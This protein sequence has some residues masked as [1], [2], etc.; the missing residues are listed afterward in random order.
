M[1]F[2][3]TISIASANPLNTT[4]DNS[5]NAQFINESYDVS[6]DILKYTHG[7]TTANSEVTI[8]PIMDPY[9]LAKAGVSGALPDRKGPS[10]VSIY[11]QQK[12]YNTQVAINMQKYE[13][14]PGIRGGL[15]DQLAAFGSGQYF[16]AI[17]EEEGMKNLVI[18][19]TR[20]NIDN[21]AF[22]A[23]NHP[24]NPLNPSQ[25]NNVTQAVTQSN[26]LTSTPLSAIN[27]TKAIKSAK[28]LAYS[29][30][31]PLSVKKMTLFVTQE[32]E[33]LAR[34]LL[35]A[36][37]MG[38]SSTFGSSDSAGSHSNMFSA[39]GIELVVM[40]KYPVISGSS[41]ATDWYLC[42]GVMQPWLVKIGRQ[43]QLTK[44]NNPGDINMFN[45][46]LMVYDFKASFA[47]DL[48]API[49]MI[50]CTA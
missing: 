26:L 25:I 32:L 18:N 6:V 7:S 12:F 27:L 9:Q 38:F 1:S 35:Q 48:S 23:T 36:S 45:Q 39:Y 42:T 43:P 21:L 29:N 47:V 2:I 50:K 15:D 10:G 3:P 5:A 46:D 28:Q 4:I 11:L 33:T 14:S 19:S 16:R 31:R 40:N 22:F 41:V 20:P 37:F 44:N 24:V 8:V 34:H 17:L 13:L 49:S 30:G